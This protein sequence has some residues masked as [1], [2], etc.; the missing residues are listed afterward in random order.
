[1]FAR[2]SIAMLLVCGLASAQTVASTKPDAPAPDADARTIRFEVT[3]V[4]LSKAGVWSG[5]GPTDDGYVAKYPPG[6]LISIAF[7]ANDASRVVGLPDWARTEVYSINAKVADADVPQWKKLDGKDFR[8]ALKGLLEDRFGL[9][10]HTEMREAPAYALVIAK[11][12][13]KMTPAKPIDTYPKSKGGSPLVGTTEKF[14]PGQTNGRLIGQAASMTQ[15]AM[16]LNADTG[17][18]VI[19]KTGLTGLY[20]FSMPISASALRQN[21]LEPEDSDETSIFT[22]LQEFLGLKLE[23][24]KAPVEFLVIDHIERPKEN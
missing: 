5:P 13:L 14:D 11:G 12:S 10:A 3:S 1:M 7:Q 16:Y 18:P 19:D 4:K 20:D 21:K 23:P 24:V 6:L 9:V 2:V 15:L 17:R 8:S 22:S